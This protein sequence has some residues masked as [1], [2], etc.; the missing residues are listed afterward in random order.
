MHTGLNYFQKCDTFIKK[1][2]LDVGECEFGF[3]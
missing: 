3:T 1:L 2:Y